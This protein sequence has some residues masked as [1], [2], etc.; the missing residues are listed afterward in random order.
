MVKC[1]R[2]HGYSHAVKRTLVKYVNHDSAEFQ[3]GP[4]VSEEWEI[5]FLVQTHVPVGV[6]L[7]VTHSAATLR[8][9]RVTANARY[10]GREGKLFNFEVFAEDAGGEI[11]RGIQKRAIVLEERLGL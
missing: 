4:L 11:G 2:P 6:A 10:V 3:G 9:A 7:N 1:G 8:G 5:V